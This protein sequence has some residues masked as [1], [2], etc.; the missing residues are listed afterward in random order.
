MS[1]DSEDELIS[2][3]CSDDEKIKTILAWDG[4]IDRDLIAIKFY[5]IQYAHTLHHILGQ[6]NN[7]S[8]L[9]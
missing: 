6:R 2:D 8:D 3:S 5:L 1:D 7:K 9:W 4:I